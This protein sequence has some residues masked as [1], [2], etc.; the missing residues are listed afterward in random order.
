M[1]VINVCTK[2]H[3]RDTIISADFIVYS[4]LSGK[5]NWLRFSSHWLWWNL[6]HPF[7]FLEEPYAYIHRIS[8]R[9]A[10]DFLDEKQIGSAL[11]LLAVPLAITLKEDLYLEG[12]V[13]SELLQKLPQFKKYYHDPASQ[14]QVF[15]QTATQPLHKKNLHGQ[16]FTLGL[17]S[18]YS[19]LIN[20]TKQ[21][22][23]IKPLHIL[24][25]D[26]FDVP[27]NKKSFLAKIHRRINYVGKH[28][29]LRPV[30][31][32]TTIRELSDHI[33][34][35]GKYHVS[36]LAAVG[37]LSRCQ[38]VDISGESF[39]FSDWGLRS[40]V[41]LLFST[42]ATTFSL[43]GHTLSRQQKLKEI[44]HSDLKN[45]FLKHV[46]VCWENVR[47]EVL[48]YNCSQCQKCWK[49]QL[50]LRAFGINNAPTFKKLDLTNL[51]KIGLVNHVYR[52]WWL[53]HRDLKQRFGSENEVVKKVKR[54]L[55]KPLRV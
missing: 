9:M 40:G 43:I 37:V 48:E 22:A 53:I 36:A 35:W 23:S 3:G 26:G 6:T 24:Y 39:E 33:I 15:T 30:Y 28:L 18:F 19:L 11:F 7:S 20:L 47:H 45:L 54:L 2:R 29:T 12:A 34:G 16:F 42:K 4:S 38:R 1:K 25:V 55:D 5:K 10:S 17:D 14:T 41:D 51:E 21:H 46:R 52:D 50:G 31:I 27:P 13:S 8:I 44:L 32:S 49:T